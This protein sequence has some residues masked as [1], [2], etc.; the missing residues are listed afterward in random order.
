MTGQCR[1]LF[2]KK[3]HI[4]LDMK[5][6]KDSAMWRARRLLEAKGI[7]YAKS[8]ACEELD[9]SIDIKLLLFPW[10]FFLFFFWMPQGSIIVPGLN[11]FSSHSIYYLSSLLHLSSIGMTLKCLSFRICWGK[12]QIE[13]LLPSFHSWC[14]MFL[15]VLM[16]LPP[17]Y[18]SRYSFLMPPGLE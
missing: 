11:F 14:S 5:D 10:F 18:P 15:G 1:T 12:S 6:R 16:V 3:W 17:T 13:Y 7:A 8:W 2:L 9:V 4:R